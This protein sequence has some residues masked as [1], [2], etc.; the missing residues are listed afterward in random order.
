MLVKLVIATHRVQLD[1]VSNGRPV[2]IEVVTARLSAVEAFKRRR[3]LLRRT[4]DVGLHNVGEEDGISKRCVPVRFP[5]VR[6]CEHGTGG[7]HEVPC[8][9]DGAHLVRVVRDRLLVEDSETFEE[10]VPTM[11]SILRRAV[12]TN[13]VDGEIGTKEPH[14]R[15]EEVDA[16]LD[17]DLGMGFEP[18]DPAHHGG[19][20]DETEHEAVAELS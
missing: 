11:R 10:C 3:H 7:R 1:V 8:I 20:A 4:R 14:G 19:L 12:R 17:V 2:H 6:D 16:T 13:D 9:L 5:E 18:K 15:E